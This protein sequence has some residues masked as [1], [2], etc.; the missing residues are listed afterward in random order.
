MR[1]TDVSINIYLFN[2]TE[3]VHPPDYIKSGTTI[4]HIYQEE[5]GKFTFPIPPEQEQEQI[6]DFLEEKI[7]QFDELTSKIQK[8]ITLDMLE[9]E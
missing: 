5:Y 1:H 8:Q 9:Q 2:D 4:N 3:I 6:N 7:T